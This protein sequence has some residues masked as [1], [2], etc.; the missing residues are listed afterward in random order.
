MKVISC[1]KLVPSYKRE[2]FFNSEVDDLKKKKVCLHQTDVT[3]CKG[4]F[5][6]SCALFSPVQN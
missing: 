2:V 3:D 1:V 4:I 6:T 5:R